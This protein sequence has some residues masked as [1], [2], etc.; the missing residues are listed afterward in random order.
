[1]FIWHVLSILAS[2]EKLIFS[3]KVFR[4]SHTEHSKGKVWSRQ[5]SKELLQELLRAWA[6]SVV[7][8]LWL[9]DPHAISQPA[10]ECLFP[11]SSPVAA[12][13]ASSAQG[14]PS[15]QKLGFP[16]PFLHSCHPS[17]SATGDLFGVCKN[18]GVARLL[19]FFLKKNPLV[20]FTVETRRECV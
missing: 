12:V 20:P 16:V 10:F 14:Q 2:N 4:W 15:F 8:F 9:A 11:Y 3:S 19:S 6:S 1:M 7:L 5:E 18:T 13:A 17:P